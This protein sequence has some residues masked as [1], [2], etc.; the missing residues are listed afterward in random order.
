M[1]IKKGRKYKRDWKRPHV[2]L[3]QI[4]SSELLYFLGLALF[5]LEKKDCS[6]IRINKYPLAILIWFDILLFLLCQTV[7]SR[8]GIR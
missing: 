3:I 8:L 1:W 6:S 7:C 5:S 4:S 2:N